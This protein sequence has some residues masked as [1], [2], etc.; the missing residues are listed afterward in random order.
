MLLDANCISQCRVTENMGYIQEL[1][2]RVKGKILP[3]INGLCS[4]YIYGGG[5]TMEIL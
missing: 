2:Y 4:A 5:F 1:E 3:E